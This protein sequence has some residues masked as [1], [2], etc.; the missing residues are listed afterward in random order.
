MKN[1]RSVVQNFGKIL[2]VFGVLWALC[3]LSFSQEQ[4]PAPTAPTAIHV[5]AVQQTVLPNK[6]TVA[7][8]TRKNVP[9]VTVQLLVKSGANA[10]GAANAGLAD[11]TA[12]LLTKGTKTRSATEI[13]E[14]MEFLGG[15]ISAGAGWNSS[16]VYVNAMSDK[17]DQAMAIMSDVILNPA[18]DQKEIDLLK[19]QYLDGLSFSLKQPG[20]LA[21]YAASKYSFEEHPAGGTV[22]SINRITQQQ[23]ND[24]HNKRFIP[25]NCVLIFTGDITSIQAFALAKK[26]FSSW[27]N[28][29]PENPHYMISSE[30]EIASNAKTVNRILVIDL[31]N[32]GQASVNYA[33]NLKFI[34]REE[35][36]KYFP[37]TVLN[38]LL[39]GGYSS[40]LNQEIRIKRG[41]SYGAGSSFVWRDWKTNFSTRTQTKNESAAEVAELVVKEI[42]RLSAEGIPDSELTPRKSVLTGGF[43]R[44]LETTAGLADQVANLYTFDL[45]LTELNSYTPGVNGVTAA[46]IKG[47]ASANFKGGDMIIV[48]DAKMFMDDL[49]KRFP[50]MSITVIKADELD[51]T[52]DTLIKK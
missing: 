7:V 17:T 29:P 10:E 2:C 31:P 15:G 14:E 20:F 6:L 18:F 13:A 19:S 22:D 24:F 52:S 36:G 1:L 34:R 16:Q 43:G 28:P 51:L 42:E 40:R 5:P 46:Q 33:K 47:F 50:G 49:K 23:I 4:P 45:P 44:G 32:S 27:K 37:A 26:F 35:K 9:L 3:G 25:E 39:G 41:L 21:T 48:G 30:K 8:V 12:T 38:S 11:M